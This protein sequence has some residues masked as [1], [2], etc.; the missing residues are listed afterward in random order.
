MLTTLE[1][2]LAK[3]LAHD[4]V[5]ED[6]E[7]HMHISNDLLN[8]DEHLLDQILLDVLGQLFNC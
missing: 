7:L 5:L 4:F 2:L 1:G 6:Y 8:I 3:D